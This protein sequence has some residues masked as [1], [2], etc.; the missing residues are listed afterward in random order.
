MNLYYY[1]L[2]STEVRNHQTE[3]QR[4]AKIE[5]I[6]RRSKIVE[7]FAQPSTRVLKKLRRERAAPQVKC[8]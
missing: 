7:F 5:Q 8:A 6:L 4:Q 1:H 3:L 2:F